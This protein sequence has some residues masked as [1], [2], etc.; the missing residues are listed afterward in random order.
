VVVRIERDVLSRDAQVDRRG[1]LAGGHN[2]DR[3]AQC[4]QALDELSRRCRG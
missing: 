1:R 2:A 3:P 4:A